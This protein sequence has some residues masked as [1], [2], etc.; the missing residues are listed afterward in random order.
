[1]KQVKFFSLIVNFYIVIS[2]H[3]EIQEYHDLN[4]RGIKYMRD[5]DNHT[6]DLDDIH[7]KAINFDMAAFRYTE[8]SKKFCDGKLKHL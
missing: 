8:R 7:I 5:E 3:S 4:H 6:P 2:V 1:M